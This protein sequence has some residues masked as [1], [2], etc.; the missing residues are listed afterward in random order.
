MYLNNEHIWEM[1]MH[2]L[3]IALYDYFYTQTNDLTKILQSYQE[4][5]IDLTTYNKSNSLIRDL[6]T[7]CYDIYFLTIETLEEDVF[8]LVK[9]IQASNIYALIILI[10]DSSTRITEAVHLHIFDYLT[11]PLTTSIH[12]N[13][14]HILALYNKTK[15]YFYFSHKKVLFSV[16]KKDILFFEKRGRYVLLHT[17]NRDYQYI[18]TTKELFNQITNDFLQI[19]HSYIINPNY[20]SELRQNQITLVRSDGVD[21]K[22][23]ILPVSRKYQKKVKNKITAYINKS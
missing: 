23:Y 7:T 21:K 22:S 11:T 4:C 8:D 1:T 15:P 17:V 16:L 13:L 19:H 10:S 2:T 9:T 5:L 20:F 3:K 12:H 6:N 14:N 18:S